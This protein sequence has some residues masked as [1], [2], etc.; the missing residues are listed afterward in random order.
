MDWTPYTKS[1]HESLQLQLQFIETLLLHRVELKTGNNPM[2]TG[3]YLYKVLLNKSLSI[4]M[5]MLTSFT[6][7][8]VARAMFTQTRE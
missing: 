7:Y 2:H 5:L 8:I 1:C 6:E 3:I 4:A